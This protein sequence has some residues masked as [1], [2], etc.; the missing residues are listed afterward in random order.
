MALPPEEMLSPPPELMIAA[1]T[2]PPERAYSRP[3]FMTTAL[4]VLPF[5]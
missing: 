5:T 2:V 4:T 3:P 1:L